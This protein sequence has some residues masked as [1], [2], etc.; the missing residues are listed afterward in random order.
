MYSVH[1]LDIMDKN[2][3]EKYWFTRN[4]YAKMSIILFRGIYDPISFIYVVNHC[5]HVFS[6]IKKDFMYTI[7]QIETLSQSVD[8][9]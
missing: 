7:K 8:I 1:L 6:Y 5:V 2:R 4:M 3:L 9:E